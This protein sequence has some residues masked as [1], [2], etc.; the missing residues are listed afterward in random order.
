MPL[1]SRQA[2]STARQRFF[3]TGASPRGLVGETILASWRRC[4]AIGL[5]PEQRLH[6][7]PPEQPSLRELRDRNELLLRS[8][9]PELELLY[10][11]A[12][13]SNSIVILAAPDSTIV[14]ASGS[15]HFLD[16]AA[17][18]AL[19][20]GV[21][22]REEL[23]GTNAIGTALHE[24][25]PVEV[26]GG[27]HYFG[28]HRVLSCSASPIL[29]GRGN[30]VGLLDI[31]GES[32]VH[33]AHAM[34]IVQLAVDQIERR[35]LEREAI[36]RD[37]I[38]LH[39]DGALLDTSREGILVFEDQRLVAANRHAIQMLGLDWSEL[40]R[41]RYHDLF[42]SARPPSHLVVPLRGRGGEIF[43][44]KR[45]ASESPRIVVPGTL[46]PHKPA[47]PSSPAIFFSAAQET[48][49]VR[50]ARLLDA[51]IPVLLQGET[52][53]GKE[54]WAREL[55]RRSNRADR[56]FV[57]INCAALPES[58]IEAELFGYQSGAFTG[59]RRNG[60]PG[61]LREADGGVL[62][63]DEIGDMPVTLQSR[64][65]RVLQER[66]VLPLG[67]SRPVKVD[68]A[69][70][71]ATLR[72]LDA[73]VAAGRFRADLYYRIAQSS[74]TLPPLRER[75]D[76]LALITW[77]WQRLGA[78]TLGV[79]LAPEAIELLSGYH[80]PGNIRQLSGTLKSLLTLAE[81]GTEVRPDELP[82]FLRQPRLAD[83]ARH[84]GHPPQVPQLQAVA[85]ETMQTALDACSGNVSEAAR[86]L[87]VSRSTLYRHLR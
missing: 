23:I 51:D 19:R 71:A 65:L 57:T 63:L 17:R 3:E 79:T 8:C 59:A 11:D 50:G 7:E 77:A 20:P 85:R 86:R 48:Q 15:T 40:G 45:Q 68:F 21:S 84:P 80:W 34:G 52:G 67:S 14:E 9:R 69:V 4:R 2:I 31:S 26:R 54:V 1:S 22:W 83:F 76:C 60:A 6:I 35:L 74:I 58:L 62:F 43:Q 28:D 78:E 27:E 46:P 24:R 87:G 25:R 18:V 66:E 33:Q 73:E 75:D 44:A 10:S 47:P 72:P 55:H 38:R 82:E 5:A 42:E 41:R 16:K 81:P 36:G 64:L 70:I 49:L 53:T 32:S 56:A 13:T 37:V 39:H 12:R 29:D 61:L 30:P